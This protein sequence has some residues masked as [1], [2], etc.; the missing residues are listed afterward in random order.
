MRLSKS[1]AT[2]E[3]LQ[4]G[5]RVPTVINVG[6]FQP[7]VCYLKNTNKI[8]SLQDNLPKDIDQFPNIEF[9][10]QTLP[11]YPWHKGGSSF[12]NI[13]TKPEE[14]D[15]LMKKLGVKIC[16]DISHTYL[17]SY[18]FKFDFY[19]AIRKIANQ[20]SHIHLS[21]ANGGNGEGLG[22][23]DGNIDFSK[24]HNILNGKQKRTIIPE[25]WMGHIDHAKGF[26]RAIVDFADILTL[27]DT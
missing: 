26:K 11:P 15:K 24:V 17:S 4:V 19:A 10:I 22:I 8:S 18:E 16:L 6:G 21:D 1:I 14:I 23:G 7:K 27:S 12:H 3:T 5:R 9:L 2:K 20:C 13:M 25:I